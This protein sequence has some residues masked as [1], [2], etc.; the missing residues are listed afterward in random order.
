MVEHTKFEES[1]GASVH[2]S[3]LVVEGSLATL[4]R[5]QEMYN[6]GD[7]TGSENLFRV[8]ILS[9]DHTADGFYGV[10]ACRLSRGDLAGACQFLENAVRLDPS[11]ANAYY[12]LGE[13]ADRAGD[14]HRAIYQYQRALAANPQHEGARS[15]LMLFT[16]QTKSGPSHTGDKTTSA[17]STAAMV[18]KPNV[19]TVQSQLADGLDKS[20]GSA[21][22]DKYGAYG[23][24]LNDNFP[25]SKQIVDLIDRLRLTRRPTFT[26]WVG[27]L[28]WPRIIILLL[29][30]ISAMTAPG[31]ALAQTFRNLHI[32]PF[33]TV[34]LVTEEFLVSILGL[35]LAFGLIVYV[36][37]LLAQWFT[38]TYV[39][40]K[41]RVQINKGVL[42]TSTNNLE[43]FRVNDIDLE[44][45]LINRVTG[46]GT[47]VF[48]LRNAAG[49][50]E[51]DSLKGF[52]KM[53]ELEEVRVE[54]LNLVGLLRTHPFIKGII[55]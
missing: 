9:T 35:L 48:T 11:N 39:I 53:P 1:V 54:L 14:V 42:K 13:T 45:T 46:D 43:L 44:R 3:A 17:A 37:V 51:V 28:P 18:A 7:L 34:P 12:L 36:S 26:G 8:L 2:A 30:A 4:Q 47:L 22:Y 29:I 38:I 41:G 33:E 21:D 16:N 15:K 23:F 6:H 25:T 27:A 31:V 40:D 55:Y 49:S 20:N 5:A 52:A 50:A 10:G 32:A 19:G 24:L